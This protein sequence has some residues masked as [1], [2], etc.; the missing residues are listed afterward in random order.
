MLLIFARVTGA[1]RG[2]FSRR[3]SMINVRRGSTDSLAPLA[4][5]GLAVALTAACGGNGGGSGFG[6]GGA[7]GATADTGHGTTGLPPGTDSSST[8]PL[9]GVDSGSTPSAD[10]SSASDD[11]PPSARLIYVTGSS[12]Q[13]YSYAPETAQFTL[14]GTFDCLTDPTHMTVDRKGI[15]WVVANGLLYNA[16]T[17]TAHCEA[18]PNWTPSVEFD[19]FALT[20]VGTT[21]TDT[22]LYLMDDTADLAAFNT[23]TGTLTPV[24][25]VAGL[26]DSLGDM[27]SN[28]DGHLYF[29]HDVTQQKLFEITPTTGAVVTSWVTGETGGS[30]EALAFYGGLFYDFLDS[31]VFTFDATTSVA[32]PIG[33]APLE[34]TGAGQSTCV[35]TSAPPPATIK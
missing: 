5:F 12:N 6:D 22:T 7:G 14:I 8:A 34:V 28:G 31:A 1:T 29:I 9:H 32:T 25:T 15:A 23:V 26:S 30:S 3:R 24:T 16:S 13:L 11:C 27:T 33:T 4:A 18:A 2:T 19:D 17:A 20:F 35:P 21:G 10:G